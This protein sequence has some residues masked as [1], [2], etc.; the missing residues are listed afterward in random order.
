MSQDFNIHD[1]SD[2]MDMPRPVSGSRKKMSMIDR[3]AQF[4]PFA[5]LT[6]YEDAVEE[7]ARLTERETVLTEESKAM[8]DAKLRIIAE[9]LDDLPEVA[10]THFVPDE[11]K[12]G[13]AYV[14]TVGIVRELD[15][16]GGF[17]VMMDRQKIAVEHIRDVGGK[18]FFGGV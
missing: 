1:Y 5:A 11:K 13:G 6:G 8:L 2:I 18:L 12:A 9:R 3:G 17:V 10:I 7:T 15:P 14:V 4:S 16:V